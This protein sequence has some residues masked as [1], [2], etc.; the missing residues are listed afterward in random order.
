[1][2]RIGRDGGDVSDAEVVLL[3]VPAA[4]TA[5]AL[6]KLPGITGKTVIDATN[7]FGPS[8]RPATGRVRVQR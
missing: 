2:T 4:A 6:D 3:A 8:R 1:V 7:L 5:E